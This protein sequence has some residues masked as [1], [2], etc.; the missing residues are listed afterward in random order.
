[1]TPGRMKDGKVLRDTEMKKICYMDGC[2]K[3]HNAK[4]LCQAHYKRLKLYG[5]PH[6]LATP[7]NKGK[8]CWC[9]GCDRPAVARGLCNWHRK[10]FHKYGDPEKKITQTFH[11]PA[12]DWLENHIFTFKGSECVEW[13][14]ARLDE[15][16]LDPC[17]GV[18]RRVTTV[19]RVILERTVG[20]PPSPQ[21]VAARTCKGV[22]WCVNPAHL[23][24]MTRSEAWTWRRTNRTGHFEY[25]PAG[26]NERRQSVTG[27]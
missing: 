26:Q 1:M 21:H 6:L 8:T 15:E 4:G 10:R 16:R 20:P 19:A 12:M 17:I 14:F 18:N 23:A 25:R 11:R 27:Y 22:E 5:S 3:P 24:W 2:G 7:K 13:P 9:E